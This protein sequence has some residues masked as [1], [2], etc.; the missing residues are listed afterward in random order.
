MSV[1]VAVTNGE[2]YTVTAGQTDSGDIVDPGGELDVSVG[3]SII[4]TLDN[5]LVNVYGTATGTVV[6]S[7]AYEVVYPGG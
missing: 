6:S 2:I 1:S 3:G 4:G 5:G 7:V